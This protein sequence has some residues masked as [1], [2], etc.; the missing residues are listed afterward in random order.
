MTSRAPVPAAE[1]GQPRQR[2]HSGGRRRLSELE[3]GQSLARRGTSRQ[4]E[5]TQRRTRGPGRCRCRR[6]GALPPFHPS[7]ATWSS[8]S[9]PRPPQ[10]SGAPL[11]SRCGR[12]SRATAASPSRCRPP[13]SRRPQLR[14][15]LQG[16][17]RAFAGPHCPRLESQVCA[18]GRGHG[19][20]G[21]GLGRAT[22][23]ELG[24]EAKAGASGA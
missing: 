5:T 16:P 4:P 17:V 10:V 23:D 11:G 8:S 9:R 2:W 13:S 3:L 6:H 15:S 12:P 14:S 7:P 20:A 24:L 1:I 22:L 21:L 19:T 18:P